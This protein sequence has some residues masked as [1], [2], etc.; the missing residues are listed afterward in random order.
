[1]DEI[2]E[3][4]GEFWNNFMETFRNVSVKHMK[5]FWGNFE[6]IFLNC[7][8][9]LEIF[10]NYRKNFR[11]T[12]IKFLKYFGDTLKKKE[13]KFQKVLKKLQG[14]L[15]LWAREI[16]LFFVKFVWGRGVLKIL[17]IWEIRRSIR[18]RT[19]GGEGGQLKADSRDI[20]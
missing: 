16:D 1:M 7:N 19:G 12:S 6:T 14:N 13:P 9:T 15:P 8:K 4:F 11:N 2:L 20:I 10:K 17:K 5:K 18:W 3:K